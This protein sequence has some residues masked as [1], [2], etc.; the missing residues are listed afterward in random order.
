M[1]GQA[2]QAGDS[3]KYRVN[4]GYPTFSQVN[5]GYPTKSRVP[6]IYP[7][8]SRVPGIYPIFTRVARLARLARPG[9]ACLACQQAIWL[10]FE[11]ETW[12][13]NLEM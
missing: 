5:F 11:S 2:G 7:T 10:I 4:F 13:T 3:G 1:P 6:E 8:K 12:A 9:Q